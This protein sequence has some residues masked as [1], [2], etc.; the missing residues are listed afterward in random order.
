MLLGSTDFFES[1]KD[2]LFLLGELRKK[3]FRVLLGNQRN[4]CLKD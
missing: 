3:E 4:V 2:I 1:S